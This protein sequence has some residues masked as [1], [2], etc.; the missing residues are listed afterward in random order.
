MF[1]FPTFLHFS[2]VYRNILG[3]ANLVDGDID[4]YFYSAH[5]A[6]SNDWVQIDMLK[7]ISVKKILVI[8][9]YHAV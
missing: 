9:K 5:P 1:V 4:T 3:A 8:R 2:P 7:E 6:I